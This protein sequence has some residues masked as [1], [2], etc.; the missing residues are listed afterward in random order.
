VLAVVM[1]SV[2]AAC[3]GPSVEPSV[4]VPPGSESQE[5][6]SGPSVVVAFGPT[7]DI[8]PAVVAAS[9]DLLVAGT[10]APGGAAI[11]TRAVT[12]A[13]LAGL[14]DVLGVLAGEAD[15]VCVLGPSTREAVTTV[16]SRTSGPRFCEVPAG[17]DP[18]PERTVAV[19]L[20]LTATAAALGDVARLAAD[21]RAIAVVV[22]VDPIAAELRDWVRASEAGAAGPLGDDGEG[23][24]VGDASD[25]GGQVP[26]VLVRVMPS[27]SEADTVA[28]RIAAAGVAVVVL[29]GSLGSLEFA[30][31]LLSRG[32]AVV[33][34][35]AVAAALPDA[36]G[37]G[38][39]ATWDVAWDVAVSAALERLLAPPPLP[40]A[41]LVGVRD[42]V[43]LRAG[44]A[45]TD[46][47]RARVLEANLAD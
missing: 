38:V 10:P 29:D 3:A 5:A 15:V 26:G 33:A 21:G 6:T 41:A 16:V 28:R 37:D 39:V 36:L 1:G 18:I 24:G 32:M 12:F 11:A 40:N 9:L 47:V 25:G 19:V 30:I 13:S 22:G 31:A 43:T 4:P 17:P 27:A 20:P 34:P 14:V 8:D 23:E 45:A 35:T 7:D 42:L 44:P 2:V 46:A